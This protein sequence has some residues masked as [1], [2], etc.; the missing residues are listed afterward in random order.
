LP[1]PPERAGEPPAGGFPGPSGDGG[2]CCATGQAGPKKHPCPDCQM[3]QMCAESRCRVCRGQKK[4]GGKVSFAEQIDR[5][6]QL[7]AAD[8]ARERAGFSR[9]AWLGGRD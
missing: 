9:P 4:A 1:R 7:N 3:C 2:Q 5:Y 8:L 6:E